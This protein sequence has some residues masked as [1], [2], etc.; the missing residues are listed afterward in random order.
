M[1]G[2]CHP[3]AAGWLWL[4]PSTQIL[5]HCCPAAEQVGSQGF[6]LLSQADNSCQRFSMT[7]QHGIFLLDIN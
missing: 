5:S 7:V 6:Q 2:T 1:Q 4:L 3:C